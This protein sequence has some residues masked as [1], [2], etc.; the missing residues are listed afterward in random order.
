MLPESDRSNSAHRGVIEI[1]GNPAWWLDGGAAPPGQQ[2]KGWEREAQEEPQVSRWRCTA[3]AAVKGM[4]KR[5]PRGAVESQG[6]AA[7]PGQQSKGWEREAQEEPWSLKVA[8][9]RRGSSQRDGKEK[10]KR[11]PRVFAWAKL[12]PRFGCA[13]G[14]SAPPKTTPPKTAPPKT[15]PPKTLRS[16]REGFA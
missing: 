2:S 4:G 3:G 8:L 1:C 11:S 13:P 15:A 5:S 7:P 9:H 14:G 6:G 10:S 16:R 12:S